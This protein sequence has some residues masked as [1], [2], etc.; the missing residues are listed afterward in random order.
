MSRIILQVPMPKAL[1][2]EAVEAAA[3]Q[4]FSSLQEAIRVFLR[5]LSRRE[6]TFR[7]AESEE[8]LSPAAERRY[9]KIIKDIKSGK[10]KTV[11]FTNVDRLMEYLNS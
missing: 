5:K 2:D 10:V 3:S 8:R 6:L 11:P 9:A 7:V 4:G 1:R